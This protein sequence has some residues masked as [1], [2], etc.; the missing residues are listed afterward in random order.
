[1]FSLSAANVLASAQKHRWSLGM[2]DRGKYG[3]NAHVR[4]RVETTS[5]SFISSVVILIVLHDL[6]EQQGKTRDIAARD[7]ERL[8]KKFNLGI[9]S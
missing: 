1:V 5:S 8:A 3:K 6:P 7:H 9:C 2:L 4:P